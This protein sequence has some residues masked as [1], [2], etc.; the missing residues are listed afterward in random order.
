MILNK[1]LT[2]ANAGDT[3]VQTSITRFKRG[4]EAD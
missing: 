4:Y 1:L 3:N 2:G